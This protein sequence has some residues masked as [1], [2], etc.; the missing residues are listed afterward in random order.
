MAKYY[1]IR[2]DLER[3]PDAWCYLVWSKRGP[4]KTYST[5][6]YCIEEKI[7][8]IFMKRT[9]EDIN[10]M[11]ARLDG[12]DSDLSPFAPLNRDFGWSI[13]PF[14][15]SNKG[16][17]AFYRGEY[18]DEGQLHPVGELLGWVVACSSVTK[19]KGFSME[20]DFII[21]DEFIP[22][23]WER[24]NKKEG[25][26]VLDMY[27][28]VLRDRVK[29]GKKEIKLICLANATS[30]N[31]P[32]FNI[33]E[34][35]D[36]AADMD[37]TGKEYHLTEDGTLLHAIPSNFDT[38]ESDIKLGIQKRMEGTPWGVMAFG[39]SFGY[40]DYTAIGKY[41]LKGFRPVCSVRFKRDIFYIY[42][43]EGFYYMTKT[44]HNGEESYNLNIENDQKRFYYDRCIDLRESCINGEMAFETYT[45]YDLIINFRKFFNI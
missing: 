45:M 39:G 37:I 32:I 14:I 21:F 35:V 22:K 28:T 44:R 27:M 26:S 9:I 34:V 15:I 30:L 6:R 40:N 43:K 42:N 10:L 20:A 18:D 33:L 31:N 25:D 2:E 13:Y 29:R 5:L 17:A 11:C 7:K 24:V 19:F 3:Y 36:I 4:G 1:D 8:F 16:L 12:D 41:N 38:Q 23:P